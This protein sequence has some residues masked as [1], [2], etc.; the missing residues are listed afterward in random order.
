MKNEATKTLP[1]ICCSLIAVAMVA[2]IGLHEVPA[3]AVEVTR[4]TEEIALSSVSDRVI[5]PEKEIAQDDSE[6]LEAA[7]E[8]AEEVADEAEAE[9]EAETEEESDS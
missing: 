4:T 1:V 5:E 2:A 8:I 7:E 6:G 9:A 3:N